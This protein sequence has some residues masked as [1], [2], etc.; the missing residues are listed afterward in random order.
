MSI[1]TCVLGLG[2]ALLSTVG[3][4]SSATLCV[5]P[6]FF[7][8]R[9]V[10]FSLFVGE[11]M[12]SSEKVRH[13]FRDRPGSQVLFEDRLTAVMERK[14]TA[15]GFDFER[16]ESLWD[17]K[18][19]QV[20]DCTGVPHHSLFVSISGQTLDTS[21]CSCDPSA[22]LV[23]VS[24][25]AEF[26]EPDYESVETYSAERLGMA[27]ET[28]LESEI[29]SVVSTMVDRAL[30]PSGYCPPPEKSTVL[31]ESSPYS[32]VLTPPGY[33]ELLRY[34]RGE[35]YYQ[36]VTADL[37]AEPRPAAAQPLVRFP[38]IHG[39][40]P[41]RILRDAAGRF[42]ALHPWSSRSSYDQPM[43][44]L[45]RPDGSM[46]RRLSLDDLLGGQPWAFLRPPSDPDLW[47]YAHHS[48][49]MDRNVLVLSVPTCLFF[50]PDCTDRD[51]ELEIDLDTGQ[52]VHPEGSVVPRWDGQFELVLSPPADEG[53]TRPQ[54]AICRPGWNEGSFAGVPEV[55]LKDLLP[56]DPLP[57]PRYT[58]IAKKARVTGTVELEI[59]VSETGEVLCAGVRKGLPMGLDESAVKT[60][61]DW[62]L[63]PHPSPSGRSR[64]EVELRAGFAILE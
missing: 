58:E 43:V 32:L 9:A 34:L 56:E 55:P 1:K 21:D 11:A 37:Y 39:I 53:R 54:R 64:A 13:L 40:A 20:Y 47:P 15:S 28:D 60:A 6:P 50:E 29:V 2:M 61:L 31:L 10:S 4:A 45:Y 36:P 57:M 19:G 35:F 7:S 59:L 8:A 51:S 41:K 48:I 23:S 17:T 25:D 16:D 30:N 3:R 33:G 44:V 46:L 62:K 22:F 5:P 63:R 26:L 14:I 18:D 27:T 49:D 42:V 38:L 52:Q 12:S 24:V